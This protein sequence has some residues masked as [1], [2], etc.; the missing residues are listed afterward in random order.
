VKLLPLWINNYKTIK[1][2]IALK[3]V[4]KVFFIFVLWSVA[5]VNAQDEALF[6]SASEAYNEGDYNK[7]VA[8]YLKILENGKHSAALYFNLGNAYYKL[9][10]IAPSIYYYE[11]ALLLTPNDREIKENLAFA[12]NM[13]LDAVEK[14][15]ET[16][17]ARLY[18]NAREWMS[19]DQWSFAA[20]VFVLLFVISYIAFYYL[21]Y[22]YQKRLAFITSITSLLLSLISLVIAFIL[23]TDFNAQEPAIVFAE[24]VVVRSEPNSRGAQAF[25]LHEG[26]K[27]EVVDQLNDYKKIQLL[28]GKTGWIPASEIKLLK[29]F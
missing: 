25:V 5:F 19:F 15:P 4:K 20:I 10:K 8:S 1:G 26:T 3:T 21:K 12:Q 24:E 18:N 7:A 17:F 9:N 28:D 6:K 23:Y 29:G 27:V 13:T 11:K 16:G 14:L 2:K 22:T